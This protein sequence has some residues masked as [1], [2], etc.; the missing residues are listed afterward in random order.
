[1]TIASDKGSREL[2]A[3]TTAIGSL[4]HHNID[5]AIEYSFGYMIPFLPQIPIRN[6]WEYMIPQALEGLP[7]LQVEK[8]GATYLDLSVWMGRSKSFAWRLAQAFEQAD[9]NPYAFEGF[10]PSPASASTWQPF[11]WELEERGAR[12]AKIQIAGPLTAQWAVHFVDS[13]QG[14]AAPKTGPQSNPPTVTIDKYPELSEQI[15]RLV[16]A[17]ALGMAR[18]LKSIRVKPTLYLDEPG[19][20]ALD[21]TKPK[22]QMALGELKILVQALRK[23]GVSVGVHC[24]SNTDW[25]A[26]LS[27]DLDILSLDAGL[28]LKSLLTARDPLV[29]FLDRGG[30]LSLGVIP[31]P[32]TPGEIR[33]LNTTQLA[34]EIY[35]LTRAALSEAPADKPGDADA[36]I[37]R[38]FTEAIYTP[39]C[40]LAYHSVS[41]AVDV[42]AALTEARTQLLELAS[43]SS[44]RSPISL[45]PTPTEH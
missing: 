33:S 38:L 3:A 8:D 27:L 34:R 43:A 41:E 21:L 42:A 22:H 35:G 13:A 20:Y 39:A 11:L 19:L 32:R 16:L 45:P 23:E 29:N 31:T 12:R 28:S 6:P 2:Y 30:R 15:F 1:M 17:R 26:L 7:G 44:A 9:S 18:R 10:E 36:R 14:S 25:K 4:P 5:A 37:R 24:C 40:G